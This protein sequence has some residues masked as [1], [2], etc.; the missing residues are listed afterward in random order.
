VNVKRPTF[1]GD[2]LMLTVALTLE[3]VQRWVTTLG[4]QSA[5]AWCT[6]N[7]VWLHELLSGRVWVH[8]WDDGYRLIQIE[9]KPDLGPG[10]VLA[11]R[12]S[13]PEGVGHLIRWDRPPDPPDR[14][15]PH[16]EP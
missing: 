4:S 2:G 10:R 1:A 13:L 15:H 3:H 5:V 14:A 12:S 16:P 6:T 9:H 7:D 11:Y 8:G